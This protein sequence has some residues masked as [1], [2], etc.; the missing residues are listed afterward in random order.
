MGC[1]DENY[2]KQSIENPL[3][4]RD[5]KKFYKEEDSLREV[6]MN[7]IFDSKPEK[8]EKKNPAWID[9]SKF[10]EIFREKSSG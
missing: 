3:R 7:S 5:L 9:T 1:E 2:L 8:D 6:Q 4:K 10:Y